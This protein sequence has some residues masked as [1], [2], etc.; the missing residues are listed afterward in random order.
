[1]K[2]FRAG[3]VVRA[4]GLGCF[5]L[6]ASAVMGLL[7]GLIGNMLHIGSSPSTRFCW[8][9]V[10]MCGALALWYLVLRIR[11]GPIL[12]WQ[13]FTRLWALPIGPVLAWLGILMLESFGPVKRE[14]V[15]FSFN[16]TAAFLP[17][18]VILDLLAV[19]MLLV[20]M[21]LTAQIPLVAVFS[22]ERTVLRL[23]RFFKNLN[24]K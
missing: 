5:A 16:T 7:F 23:V 6:I 4:D 9:Y 19:P 15:T 24:S 21:C 14:G 20:G 12:T 3:D 10:V 17:L 8:G 1:M 11:E 22:I 18:Y 2:W 13:S